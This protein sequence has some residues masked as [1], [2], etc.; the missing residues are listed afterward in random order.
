MFWK[1]LTASIVAGLIVGG[2]YFVAGRAPAPLVEIH[3]PEQYVG[4]SSELN[5][6][7][8][9]PGGE[10]LQVDV[11]I[12]QGETRA[13][14]FSLGAPGEALIEQQTPDRI[15]IARELGRDDLPDFRQ[16]HVTLTVTASRPV[17]YGLRQQSSTLSRELELRFDPPRLAVLSTQHYINHGGSEMIVYRASPTDVE[18]G[19]RVDGHFYRGYP[20][21]AAGVTGVDETT[22]VAF[23]ALLHDQELDAPMELYARD[24]AGNEARAAFDHRSFPK[25]FLRS[26]LEVSDAF[27]NQVVPAIVDRSTA[28]RA[29]TGDVAADD[30]VMQYL[31]INGDLRRDND[32]TIVSLSDQTAPQLLWQGPFHQ[33]SNSQVESGFADHRTYLYRGE[34]IDQQVHLGFD[35]AATA[36]VSILAA[37]H[38]IVIHADYLGIY[39]NC[40]VIDH[41]MG[42]QS[43]YAHLSSIDVQ[44]G[45]AVEQNQAIGQSGSTGLAGGDHLHFTMLLSGRPVTPMEWWDSHWIEDRIARKIA[46]ASQR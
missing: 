29:L 13:Q 3:D 17:F 23:F 5:L 32:E 9:A 11:T 24:P 42:L 1:F 6:S 2:A 35:L 34:E 20:A 8:E 40:V 33:L 15:R 22:R 4:Q 16:G 37:N 30:L 14:L 25:S 44:V 46:L 43:L 45:D 38:G 28:A 12:I 21:A 7:V 31:R 18:S 19:V 39:G 36:N 27:I 10:L 26:R 41:G